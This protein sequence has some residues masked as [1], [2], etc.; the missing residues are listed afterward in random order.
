MEDWADLLA[1]TRRLA[2]VQTLIDLVA[3]VESGVVIT[4]AVLVDMADEELHA[5]MSDSA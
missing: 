5:D 3:V 1:E 2:R 4:K